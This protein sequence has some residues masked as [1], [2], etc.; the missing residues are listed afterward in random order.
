MKS[1]INLLLTASVIFSTI[2][3]PVHAAEKGAEIEITGSDRVAGVTLGEKEEKLHTSIKLIRAEVEKVETAAF[4]STG[5]G[6][7]VYIKYFKAAYEAAKSV[8]P[9]IKI[10]AGGY[11]DVIYWYDLIQDGTNEFELEIIY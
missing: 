8:A 11:A 10:V 5:L 6:Q 4:N 9:D 1:L 2:C 3:I 7:D